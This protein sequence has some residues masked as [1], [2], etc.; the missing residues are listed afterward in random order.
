[1]LSEEMV[2]GPFSD[3]SPV[4]AMPIGKRF[5]DVRTAD[6]VGTREVRDGTGY[7]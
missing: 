3:A 6:Q 2:D 4:S 5:R 1:M 7:P